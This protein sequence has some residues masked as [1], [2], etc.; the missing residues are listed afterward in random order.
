MYRLYAKNIHTIDIIIDSIKLIQLFKRNGKIKK[1][2][3]EGNT[4]KNILLD[5][6]ITF[7]TSLVSLYSQIMAIID[8]IGNDANIADIGAYF[9]HNSDTQNIIRAER[10]IF[11]KYCIIC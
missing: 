1:N 4:A 11:I 6:S 8:T 9:F 3:R 2:K 10:T 5:K 7:W